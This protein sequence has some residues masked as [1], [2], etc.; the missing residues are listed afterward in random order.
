MVT[1]SINAAPNAAGQQQQQ[2]DF[3]RMQD[4][5]WLC[6]AKWKWFLVSIIVCVGIAVAYLL[7]KEPVFTRTAALLVKDDAKGGGSGINVS[8]FSDFGM[9]TSSTNVNNEM[10]TIQSPDIMREVVK[11]LHLDVAYSS[12]GTFHRET[13]Y[14]DQLPVKVAFK[15]LADNVSAGFQ[16]NIENSKIT[17]SDFTL[18]GE[19]VDGGDVVANV[20]GTVKTPVGTVVLAKGKSWGKEDAPSEIKV[21]KSPL[22]AVVDG[23]VK[24]LTIDQ[25]DKKSSIMTMSVNDV[26]IQR[27]EDLLNTLIAVYNESWVKDKNQIAVSTSMFINDRLGIIE[28]ELGH[29][30][31]DISSYK[32]ANLLPDVQAAATMYM[33]QASEAQKSV[34]ELNN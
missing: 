17:L 9:F 26:S 8:D 19:D 31:N 6:V 7:R 27:A 13:V 32:S 10:G 12:P 18:D 5:F 25:E 23:Y 11:R 21:S 4:L 30:D 28:G 2:Q 34:M 16:M 22:Q 1:T 14:G 3:I 24:S 15:S 20:G 29:V 33:T